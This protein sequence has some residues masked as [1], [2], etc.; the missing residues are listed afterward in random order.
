MSESLTLKRDMSSFGGLLITL[1]C[2]SPSIG[3]FIVGND[4]LHQV[5]TGALACFVAA[6]VLGVAMAAVYAELGSAFPHT[7]GEYTITAATL[8]PVW[9]FGILANTLI[10]YCI[11]LATSGLGVVDYLRPV[12]PGLPPVAG[13]TA[14][15]VAVTLIAI[16]SVKVNAVVTGLFLGLEI[17]TLFGTA[18]LGLL[19]AHTGNAALLLHPLVGVGQGGLRPVTAVALGAAASSAI[20]AF[21]GY[22]AVVFLGEEIRHARARMGQVVYWALGIAAVTE[23]AP[24]AGIILGA[25]DLAAMT[26]SDAPL[27]QFFRALGGEGLSRLLSLAVATAIFNTMIAVALLGGRQV[28]ASARDRAWPEVV[29][30]QLDR[31]HPRFGSPW[32]ATLL[33]GVCAL[34]I[35]AV[36]THV[37]L[38]ILGNGN[39]ALYAALSVAVIAGRRQGTTAL[40]QSRAPFHPLAP[41]FS[42]VCLAGIVWASWQDRETG[43]PGLLATAIIFGAGAAYYLLVLRRSGRWRMRGP[44][45][46]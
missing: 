7:G 35:T 12:F 34:S 40:S 19:H 16:L 39:V 36:P 43:R 18:A 24:L 25:P 26:A 20:Y 4:V 9:G 5:G 23:L 30:A 44:V 13:A 11:A 27:P 14:L 15:I 1:S 45:D 6:V 46:G 37:L 22:G 3:V 33:L 32:V 29:S 38:V 17:M 42:L 10:G 8:G 41:V 21:N 31:I 2:L 28:F